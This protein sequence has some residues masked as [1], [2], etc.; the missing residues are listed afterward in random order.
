MPTETQELTDDLYPGPNVDR[1][2]RVLQ[3]KSIRSPDGRNAKFLM[4]T[5][6][7]QFVETG[8]FDH[9]RN[10]DWDGDSDLII[11]FSSQ[12]GCGQCCPFCESGAPKKIPGQDKPVRL[13]RNLT[14]TEMVGQVENAVELP[15]LMTHSF[16]SLQ[17]AWVNLWTTMVRSEKP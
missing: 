16:V 15:R 14:A 7:G 3:S 5:S 6:D 10:P 13:I 2:V 17:W 1:T 4:M 12:D 9:R 8:V 11:C